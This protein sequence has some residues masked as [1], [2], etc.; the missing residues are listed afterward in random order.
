[1]RDGTY[2]GTYEVERSVIERRRLRACVHERKLDI[3]LGHEVSHPVR[4][5]PGLHM[6]AFLSEATARDA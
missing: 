6:R 4:E 1:V 5:Q 2:G 3:D